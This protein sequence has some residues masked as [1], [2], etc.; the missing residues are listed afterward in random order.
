MDSGLDNKLTSAI[1]VRKVGELNISIIESIPAL[2]QAFADLDIKILEIQETR[3][4]TETGTKGI[5]VDKNKISVS[6]AEKSIETVSAIHAF[7]TDTND[8]EL[9]GKVD[10]TA[11]DFYY[12]REGLL[13]DRSRLVYDIAQSNIVELAKYALSA[14]DLTDLKGRIE[15]FEKV[16]ILPRNVRGD[17]KEA[18][19]ILRQQF[20]E[21]EFI[22]KE[23]IDYIMEKIKNTYPAFYNAYRN[24]RMIINI[25]VRYEDKTT[26]T[27][28]TSA[29]T[30][31]NTTTT[32]QN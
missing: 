32:Q 31:D 25:G 24:A 27:T 17:R 3:K 29:N 23:R 19:K 7:A 15:D 20:K 26:S 28:D 22:Q 14:E 18:N 10:Y 2:K 12:C 6:L 21:L 4:I 11:S 8:S 16:I 9:I 13:L 5:T 30:T 1:A